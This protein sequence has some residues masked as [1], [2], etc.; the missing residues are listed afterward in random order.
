MTM[1]DAPGTMLV[2]PGRYW[3]VEVGDAAIK[4]FRDWTVRHRDD[5]RIEA[6][7][8][9]KGESGWLLPNRP[10]SEFTIFAVRRE[11]QWDAPPGLPNW[12]GPEVQSKADTSQRPDPQEE[13]IDKAADWAEEWQRNLGSLPTL[14]LIGLG[15]YWWSK[16]R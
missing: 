3:I 12:A 15:L 7:E 8:F 14:L 16:K 11:V 13:P 9:D 2:P 10:P 6:T 4:A 5:V 1:A